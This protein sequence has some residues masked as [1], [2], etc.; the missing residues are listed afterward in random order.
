MGEAAFLEV[1]RCL[2]DETL[3][4]PV[5]VVASV[6]ERVPPVGRDDV[7]RVAED[8]VEALARDGLEEAPLAELD[9]LHLVQAGVEGGEVQRPR[10]HVDGHDALAV[11]RG[12]DRLDARAR[13]DVE[14]RGRAKRTVRLPRIADRAVTVAT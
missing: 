12:P 10:V 14:R 5:R 9:V 13:A 6:P 3:A 2:P 7:W 8:E 1:V 11:A 4:E